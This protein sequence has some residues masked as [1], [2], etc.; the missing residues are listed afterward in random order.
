M[1]TQSVTNEANVLSRFGF[2]CIVFG[3][4]KRQN[5]SHTPEEHVS[6]QDLKT[7]EEFYQTMIEKVCL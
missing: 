7:A 4:G 2:E 6:L 5:N 1:K 3:P